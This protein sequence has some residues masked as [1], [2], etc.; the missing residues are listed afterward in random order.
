[1]IVAAALALGAAPALAEQWWNNAKGRC[2]PL[3]QYGPISSPAKAYET[4]AALG[5]DPSLRDL[6]NGIVQFWFTDVDGKRQLFV[7]LRSREICE[8]VLS[9]RGAWLDKYR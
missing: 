9:E 3:D 1:L 5:G 4:A 2:E 7:Y 6:G 8:E